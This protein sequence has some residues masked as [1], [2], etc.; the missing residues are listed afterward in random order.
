MAKE[1]ELQ[2][3]LE[4]MGAQM[5]RKSPPRPP[6]SPATAPPPRPFWPRRSIREG[7][8]TVAAGANPMALKRGI[9]KAVDGDCGSRGERRATERRARQAIQKVTGDMIAQVGTISANNDE[10]IGNIIA[11]AMKKVGK[12]GVITVE[13]SKTHGDA[14]RGRRGMQFDRGYLSPYFVTDRG[15]DGM[16]CWRTPTS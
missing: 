5:V 14:A 10:T 15:A 9:E 1:I 2:D 16:P 8:K 12:D 6:T 7:V 4:N 3:P 13:E 11:E